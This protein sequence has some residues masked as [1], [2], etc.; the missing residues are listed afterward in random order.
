MW[1][2]HSLSLLIQSPF[3]HVC[4]V[5]ARTVPGAWVTG[6]KVAVPPAPLAPDDPAPLAPDDPAPLD[7]VVG[8][9]I[10]AD[11]GAV[12]G[13]DVGAV[14]GADTAGVVVAYCTTISSSASH[15]SPVHPD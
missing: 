4:G 7:P 15:A 8:A 11:V 3:S 2:L 1:H 13:A 14:I 5:H 12:I 6:A 10:G 9:V